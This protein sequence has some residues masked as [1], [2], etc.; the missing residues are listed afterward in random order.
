MAAHD[1]VQACVSFVAR[2]GRSTLKH[3][4]AW[5][6]STSLHT[7][8]SK[9]MP[10]QATARHHPR[11]VRITRAMRMGRLTHASRHTDSANRTIARRCCPCARSEACLTIGGKNEKSPQ[12][13]P[14]LCWSIS[15]CRLAVLHEQLMKFVAPPRLSRIS[16]C[17][18]LARVRVPFCVASALSDHCDLVGTPLWL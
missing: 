14:A 12:N 15:F 7:T 16:S 11:P 4:W 5:K 1:T 10:T 2:D 3:A 9:S 18:F 13:R 8:A 6:D 17:A